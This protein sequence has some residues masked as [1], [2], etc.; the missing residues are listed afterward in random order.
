MQLLLLLVVSAL[1]DVGVDWARYGADGYFTWFGLGTRDLR[2]GRAADHRGG[3]GA[4]PSASAMSRLRCRCTCLPGFPLLQVLRVAPSILFEPSPEWVISWS[5]FDTLMIAVGLRSAFAA[6]RCRSLRRLPG[7]WRAPSSAASRSLRA[8][9]VRAVDRAERLVVEGAVGRRRRFRA[10]RIRPPSR[11]WLAQQHLLDEALT[12]LDDER[13]NVTDLYFVGFAGDAREDVFRK[14]V[15]AAQRVMDE[16][17]GTNG[18]S[19][20]LINNPRTLLE[21][22]AATRHQPPRDAERDRRR[23]STRSRTS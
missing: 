5:A 1:V 18:R 9:V 13:S 21:S 4:A 14:D 6:S 3:A 22:P 12:A 11:C 8:D 16:R 19:V 17:W 10:I 20:S 23:R 2:R 15:L 7:R